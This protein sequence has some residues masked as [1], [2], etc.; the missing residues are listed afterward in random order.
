MPNR[1]VWHGIFF[2]KEMMMIHKI[3]RPKIKK[4]IRPILAKTAVWQETKSLALML[5]GT[6]IVS[7]GYVLFQVP[8]NIAAGGISGLGIIVHH[9]TGFPIGLLFWIL[10]LPLLLVGFF[11]L[12]RWKFLWRTL[13]AAT[14]FSV[15]TDLFVIYLPQWIP[16]FPIT[17]DLL[18]STIYGGIIGGIGGGLIYRAGGTMGGTGI[19][20]RVYQKKT[21]MPLSQVY[22]YTDGFIIALAGIVFGWE[23][24][25]YA[26]LMLFLNGLASDYV[27][28]GPSSTRTATI[29]TNR[30]QAIA[31]AVID[32][33][34]RGASFWEITGGFTGE[35]HY[36]VWCTVSRP[37]VNDL[38]RVVTAVDPR[39]FITIGVS[40]EALGYGFTPIPK[41]ET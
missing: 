35:K 18:L 21:G 26:F 16:A 8:H 22:F 27:L 19:I 39:A 23:V 9:F 20:G 28:E 40:H 13:F 17:E 11:H 24:A 10:N 6:I 29:V 15:A 32:E 1:R 34:H 14:L 4:V 7:L 38:K 41:D 5:V 37:Q 3:R 33:L 36:V 25:L 31:N 12:G 2:V 30:P